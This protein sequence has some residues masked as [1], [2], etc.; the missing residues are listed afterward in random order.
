MSNSISYGKLCKDGEFIRLRMPTVAVMLKMTLKGW[1]PHFSKCMALRG[2]LYLTHKNTKKNVVIIDDCMGTSRFCMYQH[3][4]E[5]DCWS[6]PALR[7]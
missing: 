5:D 1:V 6:M 3:D 4:M 7:A 2:Q